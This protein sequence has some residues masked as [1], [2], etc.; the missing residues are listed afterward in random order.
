MPPPLPE[1]PMPILTFK[2][3]IDI[4][5]LAEEWNN[6][7]EE[8]LSI[9]AH[10]L[11]LQLGDILVESNSATVENLELDGQPFNPLDYQEETDLDPDDEDEDEEDE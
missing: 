1:I 3:S 2:T 8:V 5:E 6:S 11:E 4:E 10:N 7:Q 9:I